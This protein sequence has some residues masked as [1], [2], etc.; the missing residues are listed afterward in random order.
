M[1]KYNLTNKQIRK[2]T[3]LELI[4]R[5]ELLHKASKD[6]PKCAG[7]PMRD[8]WEA[9]NITR[10]LRKRL[11]RIMVFRLQDGGLQ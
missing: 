1:R 3:V 6:R 10:I 2:A 7:V 5:L 9:A 8:I 11:A 4:F